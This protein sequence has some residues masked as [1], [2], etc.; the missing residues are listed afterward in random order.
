[1]VFILDK[2]VD[3]KWN[4]IMFKNDVVF[5]WIIVV[6]VYV[7]FVFRYGGRLGVFVWELV[8]CCFW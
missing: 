6:C 4:F 5:F 3:I 8:G 2:V 7:G 1:M